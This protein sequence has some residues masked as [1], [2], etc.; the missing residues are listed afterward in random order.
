M[1]FFKYKYTVLIIIFFLLLFLFVALN[2]RS[3]S[4]ARESIQLFFITISSYGL[5]ISLGILICVLVLSRMKPKELD[6]VNFLEAV[7]WVVIPSI[8]VARM[9]HVLTDLEYY[10]NDVGQILNLST[11]GLSIWGAILGGALG[12]IIF[13]QLYGFS[14]KLALNFVAIVLPV[15]QAVGRAGNFLNQELFGPPTDRP[16]GMYVH[17]ANRPIKYIQNEYFHPAFLYEMIADLLLFFLLFIFAK[18]IGK[19]LGDSYIIVALYLVG[20]GIVRFFVAFYRL[21]EAFHFGLS[22]NQFVALAFV[23]IGAVYIAL[24]QLKQKK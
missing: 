21:E 22:F 24:L 11:G 2:L 12:I 19:N 10:R 16:W 5:S 6:N 23:L 8:I 9:W 20:Y 17:P 7:V 13:T 1:K 4:P 15:G 18:K 3:I 14:S